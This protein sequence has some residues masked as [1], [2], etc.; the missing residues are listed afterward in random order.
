MPLG[1]PGTN[2]APVAA[3]EDEL[4][5]ARVSAIMAKAAV[6]PDDLAKP[7]GN[8]NILTP[9][10]DQARA[11]A[12][13]KEKKST[14]SMWYGM[15]RVKN[16]P[17]MEQE[18]KLQRYRGL[19]QKGGS[20]KVSN[21]PTP[22]FYE[23]GFVVG[24]GKNK[25]KKLKSFADEWLADDKNGLGKQIDRAVSRDVRRR[26]KLK[27]KA[28]RKDESNVGG[29]KEKGGQEKQRRGGVMRGRR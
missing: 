6:T 17:E 19:A 27:A 18:L 4:R 15:K 9:A 23:T 22:E 14:L 25:R 13:K 21:D 7:R 24:T 3:T 29:K 11:R 28:L 2:K 1:A 12:A 16:T 8:G 26:K 20:M 10:E 5:D